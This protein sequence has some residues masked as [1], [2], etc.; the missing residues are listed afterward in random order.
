VY[1]PALHYCACPEPAPVVKALC[2]ADGSQLWAD[3]ASPSKGIS[4]EALLSEVSRAR[5]IAPNVHTETTRSSR[6][7]GCSLPSHS[8]S[9]PPLS[10][11]FPTARCGQVPSMGRA[12]RL[13]AS[14]HVSSPSFS[15]QVR[16]PADD[17]SQ[18]SAEV[19]SSVRL[20][21]LLGGLHLFFL[22]QALFRLGA[23]T[24]FHGCQHCGAAGR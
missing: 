17:G 22:Q 8:A 15:S 20:H 1:I 9:R 19:P 13:G 18:Q 12:R 21:L 3:K 6:A 23:P 16:G 14:W 11:S 4:S 5:H 10:A 24:V 7:C 2:N